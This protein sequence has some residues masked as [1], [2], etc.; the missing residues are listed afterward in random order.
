MAEKPKVL[1]LGG[2]TTSHG[3]LTSAGMGFIGRNVMVFLVE[4]NLTSFIRVAD[5]QVPS[6]VYLNA[7]CQAALANPGVCVCVGHTMVN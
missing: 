7:Q 5:K 3:D 1:I 6:T 2:K 4:N